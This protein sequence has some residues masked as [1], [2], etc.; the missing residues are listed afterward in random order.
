MVS[1]EMTGYIARFKATTETIVCKASSG[2]GEQI[3]VGANLE[4]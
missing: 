1:S 4:R 2:R 3:K